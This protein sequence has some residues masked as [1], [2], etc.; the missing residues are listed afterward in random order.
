[1]TN[2]QSYY[3]RSTLLAQT[4][5]VLVTSP[6]TVIKDQTEAT[7]SKKGLFCLT[8]QANRLSWWGS[9]GG[10]RSHHTTVERHSVRNEHGRSA[11]GTLLGTSGSAL[12]TSDLPSSEENVKEPDQGNPARALLPWVILDSVKLTM[13]THHDSAI[14]KYFNIKVST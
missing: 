2:Q 13:N 1:M 12:P 5:C 14:L 4:S 3:L 10:M 7:S 9:Q 8:D 6:V 11:T